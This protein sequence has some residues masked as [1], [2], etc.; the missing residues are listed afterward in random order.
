MNTNNTPE[1]DK[2]ERMA[3]AG[4]YMVPTEVAR[5][6]ESERDEAQTEIQRLRYESQRESEH[7]DKMVGEL[8][9][10][11]AER[12][13]WAA[14]CGQYKQER[15]EVKEKY[16]FAVIHWQIG[17]AKMERERDEA[18]SQRNALAASLEYIASAGL[19]ARHCEDEAKKMLA[20]IFEKEDAK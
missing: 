13:E 15:D 18:L 20:L 14:M 16:R 2:A 9:K 5:K 10:V 11:Y 3:Y 6:L 12:D 1:A 17:A 8:E 7:H 4:E 19:T